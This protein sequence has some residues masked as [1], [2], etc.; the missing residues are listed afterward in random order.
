VIESRNDEF[1]VGS[2]IFGNLGWRTLTKVDP[3]NYANKHDLYILPDYNNIPFS[4]ALGALGMPGNSAFYGFLDLCQPKEGEVVA[5]S[6][7][8]GA[9][10]TLVGQ[11]AKIKGCKVIG[12]AGS[13][14]K[15]KWLEENFQFDKALNYKSENLK[16]ELKKA[17]PNGIDCYFDNVGGMLSSIIIDQMRMYGRI[18]I[19]GAISTYNDEQVMIPAFT[20]FHRRNLK[21]E[22]FMNYR[23]IKEWMQKGMFQMLEWIRE[24]KMKCPEHI[25]ED[26]ENTPRAF[27]EMMGGKN[28]GKAIVKL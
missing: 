19:C 13:D 22:G 12:F 27:I 2:I 28:Y 16:S 4:Y 6:G 17:A 26:F 5:I 18:S 20:T 24:Q 14:E 23:W 11:I 7:A 21:M 15:C 10:G 25:T 9:V 8:A 3:K 1:R